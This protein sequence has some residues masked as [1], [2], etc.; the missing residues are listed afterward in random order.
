MKIKDLIDKYK[1]NK[2]AQLKENYNETQLRNDFI[3]PLLKCFGWD[4]DNDGGK[5]FF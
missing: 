1:K 4:V 5:N 3:D 2:I